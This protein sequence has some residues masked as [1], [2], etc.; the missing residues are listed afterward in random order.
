MI[1]TRKT[2]PQENSHGKFSL[3]EVTTSA[4]MTPLSDNTT[5][6]A[7][8]KNQRGLFAFGLFPRQQAQNDKGIKSFDRSI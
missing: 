8:N 2:Q 5:T 4:T 6:I 7:I 3:L 1:L